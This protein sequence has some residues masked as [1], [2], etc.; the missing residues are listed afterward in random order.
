MKFSAKIVYALLFTSLSFTACAA[1]AADIDWKGRYRVEGIS[2][3]NTNMQSGGTSKAYMTHHLILDPKI[4]A[5]DGVNIYGSFGILNNNKAY[6]SNSQLGSFMGSGPN[7]TSS[8]AGTTGAGDSNSLAQAQTADTL[9]VYRLYMNWVQE[10]GMLV[11]G[12]APIDFGLGITHNS[13]SGVFDHWFDTRDIVGYKFT[14]GNMF[15]MPMVGKV[16]EGN[17]QD[18]DDMNDY[19]LHF[20]YDNPDSRLGLGVFYESRVGTRLGANDAPTSMGGTGSTLTGSWETKQVSLSVTK[21][22]DDIFFGMEAAFLNGNT[23]LQSARSESVSI[24][25]F[26]I[27][28]EFQY[29]PK[30]WRTTL[31]LKAGVATGDDPS[32]TDKY[33]G[34]LFDRNYDVAFLMF[35]HVLGQYDIFRSYAGGKSP[36]GTQDAD[37]ET[38]SNVFYIVPGMN[39]AFSDT[40]SAGTKLAWANLNQK[41]LSNVGEIDKNVGV[42]W[43]VNVAYKPHDRL[44]FG[45]DLGMFVP[46]ESY[47]GGTNRYTTDTVFGAAT[48][49]AVSF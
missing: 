32:S 29:K 48:K 38:L 15:F 39:Y 12:R 40:W 26:G 1:Q 46:G 4:V 31:E 22:T 37:T 14:V 33:E 3:K 16:N 23:G 19:M 2:V 35:N 28:T 6:H 25:A 34:F 9:K 47:K 8:T 36:N 13:G 42:E 10:H 24:E 27:A 7:S 30:N 43:D 49:A 5:A 18:E 45:L 11:T 17:L 21:R 41:P 44:T 20:Q